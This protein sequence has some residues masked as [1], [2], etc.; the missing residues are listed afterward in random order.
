VPDP[1]ADPGVTVTSTLYH[2]CAIVDHTTRSLAPE[3]VVLVTQGRVSWLGPADQAPD[4]GPGVELVDAGGTT[5]VAGMVDAHRHLTLP[6]GSHWIDRATDSTPS[7]WQSPSTTPGC[8]TRRA[9]DGPATWERRSATAGRSA[10][11]SGIAGGIASATRTCALPAAG[12][13]EPAA[14]RPSCRSKSTTGTACWPTLS[15]SWTMA[16]TW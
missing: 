11:P 12:W 13:P 4:P 5:A 9:C 1:S 2:G 7:W 10:S 15:A 14:C 8:C 16:P 6:G 3:M